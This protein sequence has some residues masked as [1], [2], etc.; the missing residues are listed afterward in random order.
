MNNPTSIRP[1]SSIFAVAIALLTISLISEFIPGIQGDTIAH[2][3]VPKFPYKTE[4]LQ[5]DGDKGALYDQRLLVLN[6]P[7]F[8]QRLL[9]SSNSLPGLLTSLSPLGMLYFLL[10]SAWLFSRSKNITP[11]KNLSGM[12]SILKLLLNGII[13]YQFIQIMT[14]FYMSDV[15]LSLTAGHYHIE[16]SNIN[17]YLLMG[18]GAL[19]TLLIINTQ[20]AAEIQKEQELTI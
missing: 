1:V 4:P 15:V 13:G 20:T 17:G 12:T 5:L 14:L 18:L 19:T 8:F 7:T 16:T 2:Q 9:G 6:H 10:L 3:V 11:A